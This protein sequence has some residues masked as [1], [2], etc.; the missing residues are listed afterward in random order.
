MSD[1]I[2]SGQKAMTKKVLLMFGCLIFILIGCVSQSPSLI[3]AST[4]PVAETKATLSASDTPSPI[5]KTL[6]PSPSPSH[7]WT[8]KPTIT[9]S[10]T[11]TPI[12]SLTPIVIIPDANEP[13]C[14]RPEMLEITKILTISDG[15]MFCILWL[16]LF[17]NEIG[18]RIILKYDNTIGVN[19]SGEIFIYEVD[20]NSIQL[21]VPH[22]HAP[23][24]GESQDQCKTRSDFTVQVIALGSDG[25]FLGSEQMATEVDCHPFTLPTS[26]AT[27]TATP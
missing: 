13:K 5:P 10:Q 11:R 27:V 6:P 12:P 19:G 7:T 9:P 18:F 24:L 14:V 25:Q 8:P 26:T 4:T 21:I 20:P 16:D 22:E 15:S 2:K 1:L 3:T 23:R 17:E